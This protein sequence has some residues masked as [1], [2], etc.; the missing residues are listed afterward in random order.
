MAERRLGRFR[1]P[2]EDKRSSDHVENERGERRYGANIA[3]P[4]VEE[5]D[6]PLNFAETPAAENAAKR[7]TNEKKAPLSDAMVYAPNKFDDAEKIAKELVQG[8]SLIVNLENLLRN[9]ETTASATRVIDFLCG[10]AYALRSD[11]KRINNSTFIFTPGGGE[12]RA[13]LREEIRY[14]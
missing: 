12:E 5:N 11:V 6:D 4:Q 10:V 3:A 14:R 7:P 13:S 9:E 1:F 8:R 2:N